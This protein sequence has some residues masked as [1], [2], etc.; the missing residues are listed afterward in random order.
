MV[1][2]LLGLMGRFQEAQAQIRQARDLDPLS[3][4]INCNLAWS[5]LLARMTG[6]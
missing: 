4:V 2:K 1:R 3:L 5:Y 6:A